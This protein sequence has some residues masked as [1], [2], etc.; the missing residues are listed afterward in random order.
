MAVVLNYLPVFDF[1]NPKIITAYAREDISGG[2]LVFASGADNQ[3]SSGL[4]SFVTSDIKVAV[5]STD[6]AQFTGVALA[7]ASSGTAMSVAIEG[8][9]ILPAD[10]SVF[11]GQAIE[12][13][14]GV[15]SVRALSSGAIPSALYTVGM[16]GWKCGRALTAA[17]S[18]G[19]AVCYISQ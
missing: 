9:F 7:G 19:F 4:S 10:G 2:Q 14:G 13:L 16:P 8:A 18:G 3:V 1:G 11:A 17:V 15:D 6:S 5:C 12:Q